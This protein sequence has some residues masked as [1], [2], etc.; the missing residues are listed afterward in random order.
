MALKRI[1]VVEDS[2]DMKEIY[3]DI[4]S[5]EG[6]YQ[7]EYFSLAEEGLAR[8][9]AGERYDLIIVDIIME[10]MPGDSFFVRLRKE[11]NLETVP[12]LVATVLDEKI[13]GRLHEIGQFGY[14]QKPITKELLL[15]K[16]AQLVK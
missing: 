16:I 12:V 3:Q 15:A 6:G 11:L 4:F 1:M 9:R 13:L 7:V 5:G 2:V 8:L 10:P 14:L